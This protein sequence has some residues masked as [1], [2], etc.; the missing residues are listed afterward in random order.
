[1]YIKFLCV[2]MAV[3]ILFSVD[4]S[5]RQVTTEEFVQILNQ[6]R[7]KSRNSDWAGAV[8]LWERVVTINPKVGAFWYSLGTAQRNAGDFRKAISS[9]EKS[10]EL[11][12]ARLSTVALDIARSYAGLKEKEP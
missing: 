4:V 2:L 8:P 5:A 12:G 9:L 1:M 7:E 10:L 3:V 11:G 6:A